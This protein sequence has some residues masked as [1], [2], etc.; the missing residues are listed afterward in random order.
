LSF[1]LFLDTNVFLSFFHFADDDLESLRQLT[2]LVKDQ[3]VVL[4]LPE[5]VRQEFESKRASS[6]PR[7][8]TLSFTPNTA[9]RSTPKL[10]RRRSS[11]R[12]ARRARS[13]LLRDHLRG[14]FPR[15]GSHPRFAIIETLATKNQI[16]IA[17]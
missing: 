6:R 5:Q 16:S 7:R 8:R 10:R 9:P 13:D 15:I 1:L 12:N 11:R 2:K 14:E 3:D 4:L 17:A